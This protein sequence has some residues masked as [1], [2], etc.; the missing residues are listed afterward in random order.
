MKYKRKKVKEKKEQSNVRSKVVHVRLN[1]AEYQAIHDMARHSN[2]S[3]SKFI[4]AVV[5]Q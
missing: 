1:E 2:L 5:F 4:R 3:V